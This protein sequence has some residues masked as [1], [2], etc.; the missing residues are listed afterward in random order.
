MQDEAAG[1]YGG[2]ART[3]A[4]LHAQEIAYSA[5]DARDDRSIGRLQVI[6]WIS[7]AAVAVMVMPMPTLM[8]FEGDA[9]EMMLTADLLAG[10]RTRLTPIAKRR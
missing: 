7:T 4:R 6:E 3:G 8:L 5:N 9:I 1:E 2:S 10:K